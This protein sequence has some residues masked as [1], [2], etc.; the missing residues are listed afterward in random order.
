VIRTEQFLGLFCKEKLVPVV[1][2]MGPNQPNMVV[3]TS[4]MT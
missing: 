2:W 3:D 1:D 4:A